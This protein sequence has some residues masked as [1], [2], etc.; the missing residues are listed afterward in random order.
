VLR[1]LPPNPP[2]PMAFTLDIKGI[3]LLRGFVLKYDVR[4]VAIKICDFNDD[5]KV[6]LIDLVRVAKRYRAVPGLPSYVHEL[7]VNFDEVID[8]GDLTTVAANI[9]G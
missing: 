2:L 6:D 1:V 4:F 7:D 8:V 5:G 9:E 3:P